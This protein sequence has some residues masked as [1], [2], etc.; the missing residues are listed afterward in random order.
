MCWILQIE[1]KSSPDDITKSICRASE[2]GGGKTMQRRSGELTLMQCCCDFITKLLRMKTFKNRW[3]WEDVTSILFLN[4][5]I[6]IHFIRKFN[7]IV[8]SHNNS[9]SGRIT[10]YLIVQKEINYIKVMCYWPFP[11]KAEKPRDLPHC[12]PLCQCYVSFGT[13]RW[14]NQAVV[15]DLSQK[16]W[17]PVKLLLGNI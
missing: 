12:L 4:P 15:R 7:W 9:R 1:G 10:Q 11:S 14:F 16:R 17:K 8:E 5:V 3:K 13:Y 6:R 2:C